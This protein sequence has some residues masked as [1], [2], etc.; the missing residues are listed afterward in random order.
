MFDLKLSI[1]EEY[2]PFFVSGTLLTIKLSVVA[3]VA[4][5]FLG[6]FLALA[7]ISSKKWLSIPA[8]CFIESIRGTPLL[9][10][11]LITYFGVVPLIMKKPDGVLAAVLALSINAGAYIAETIRGGILATDPGQMEAASALGLTRW[12]SMRYVILPQAIRSVIPALGNSFVSLIKD[13]SLASVIATPELMYWANAA[14]A[15]YYRVWET[16]ITTALIY[17]FLT[18]VTSRILGKLEKSH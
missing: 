18:V 5:F 12:Q 6:L 15:Q 17:L 4:G 7:R 16:F 10:Q 3:I 11:I 8:A 2:A 14:N 9:L 1:L 13:S